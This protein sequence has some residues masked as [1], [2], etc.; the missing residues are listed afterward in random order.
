MINLIIILNYLTLI[1]FPNIFTTIPN[2]ILGYFLFTDIKDTDYLDLSILLLVSILLYIGGVVLNDYFDLK[3]DKN[4]RPSRPLPS[5]K[6]PK[7]NAIYICISCFTFALFL[8]SYT[9]LTAFLLTI[10]ILILIFIYNSYSKER[11]SGP[12]NMGL[13]RSF[14]IL[15]GAS[16]SFSFSAFNLQLPD[17]KIPIIILFEFLYV[18]LITLL[19]RNETEKQYFNTKFLLISSIIY[20]MIFSIIFLILLGIFNI[21]SIINVSIFTTVIIYVHYLSF[22]KNKFSIQKLISVLI[23]LM[24][25]FDSIFITD[26]IG[27]SYGLM[28]LLLAPLTIFLSKK[29]YM[30]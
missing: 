30:T 12:P 10:T 20:F 3:K 5:N 18:F 22:K 15:L 13:I 19:S 9:S 25:V 23:V 2:I 27:I 21:S 29:M 17:P 7:R 28:I 8:S 14:N 1:R 24:I 16:T 6:I 11:I 4:E 26:S